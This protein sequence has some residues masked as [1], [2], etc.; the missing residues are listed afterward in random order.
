MVKLS[1]CL[2]VLIESER[3]RLVLALRHS[4][5]WKQCYFAA[6]M[7]GKT[8]QHGW[9]IAAELVMRMVGGRNDG[10]G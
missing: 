5:V 7:T 6:V 8:M 4:R 3:K 2:E 1:D 10:T 9:Y